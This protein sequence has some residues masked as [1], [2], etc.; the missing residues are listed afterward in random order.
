L[1]AIGIA[2]FGLGDDVALVATILR[3]EVAEGVVD[4]GQVLRCATV[5]DVL[6][7]VVAA[8]DAPLREVAADFLA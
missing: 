2:W 5:G 6:D 1:R 3:V 7:L 8:I 4:E